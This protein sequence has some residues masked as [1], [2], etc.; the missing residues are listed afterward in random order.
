LRHYI[1]LIVADSLSCKFHICKLVKTFISWLR[2]L[3]FFKRWLLDFYLYLV[4]RIE[5]AILG[6][7][8]HSRELVLASLAHLVVRCEPSLLTL[9]IAARVDRGPFRK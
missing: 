8:Q 7:Y 1:V 5:S 9:L 2:G 3:R 4:K 6:R